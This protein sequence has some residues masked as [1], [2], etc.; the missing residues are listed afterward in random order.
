MNVAWQSDISRIHISDTT[1]LY[2]WHDSF[3]RVT[4]FNCMCVILRMPREQTCTYHRREIFPETW[5]I[6]MCD[7]THSYVWHHPFTCVI[8]LV[9]LCGKTR[10]YV[11]RVPCQE[12]RNVHVIIETLFWRHDLFVCVTW[13]M[14]MCDMTYSSIW[15]DSLISVT[16]LAPRE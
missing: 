2:L 6:Y 4:W 16:W 13:R 9:H 12:N 11:W 5:L 1:H 7:M 15:Q 14:S 3:I 8:W 10:F